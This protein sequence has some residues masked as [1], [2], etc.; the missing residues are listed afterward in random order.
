M[1]LWLFFLKKT[2]LTFGL[3]RAAPIYGSYQYYEADH[4]K[5]ERNQYR[6]N[7]QV[8]HNHLKQN[9]R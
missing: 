6:Y 1:Y 7:K 2:C 4:D 3:Y 9:N 5:D 8:V